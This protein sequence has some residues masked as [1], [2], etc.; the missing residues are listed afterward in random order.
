[1]QNKVSIITASYNYED[2]IKET[3]ESVMAQTY[4]DWEMIIVDDGSKDNSVEVIKSYCEKDS[5]I[6][7]FQHENGMNKGLPE[8]V[9][10][11]IEKA[12]G[13]WLVFLESN[14]TITP[15]YLE[16]KLKIVNQYPKVGFIFNDINMF[17]DEERIQGMKDHYF[18][19]LYQILSNFSFPA[20]ISEAFVE[21]NPVP[22]FSCV[23]AK[24]SLFEGLDFNAARKPVLD[25]YLWVQIAQD[26]EFYF[27][28]KK[29]TNWR[30]SKNSYISTKV[31]PIIDLKFTQQMN[32][33]NYKKRP[34][35]KFIKNI[36][37]YRKYVIR[38][39][40]DKICFMGKWYYLKSQK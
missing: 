6:K 10:L 19:K 8:T 12:E 35:K 28:N 31:E 37:A 3:I 25:Y 36:K 1:M 5:R 4:Q 18:N 21:I 11:G 17:G 24:K 22:T 40:S 39:H 15:D 29:L 23:M 13:E 30:M 9:K 7:L 26:N 2:Y 27:L 33:I 34:L 38:I 16:E 14:D 20:N 32:N